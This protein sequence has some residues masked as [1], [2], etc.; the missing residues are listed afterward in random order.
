MSAVS[1]ARSRTV[2]VS[3]DPTAGS[4]IAVGSHAG[5]TIGINAPRLP[6]ETRGS[7]GFSPT[8]LLLAG[9]GSCAAWDVVEILRKRRAQVT[10]IDVS[11]EGHQDAQPPWA[12]NRVALHFRIAGEK[13]SVPVVARVIRL[14]IVRYCSVI[15]TIAGVAAIEAT[16]EL[17]GPEGDSSGRHLIELAIPASVA[18]R[19]VAA[20][21]VQEP[22]ADED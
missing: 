5:K 14:S 18:A 7:T 21:G 6:D 8:E 13:L 17:V 22:A 19:D 3:W 15:T 1:S 9:A 16:V 2:S 12:Y 20:V 10:A 4:F 11:V